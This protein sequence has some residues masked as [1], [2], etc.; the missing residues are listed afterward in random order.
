MSE[1]SLSQSA[2]YSARPTLRFSGQEDARASQLVTAM[3]MDEDEGGMSRLELRLSNWASDTAGGAALAFPAGSKLALGAGIE[4]YVGD[5]AEPREIF[6]GRIS[7]IEADFRTGMPPEISVLAEDALQAARMARR[8]KV[9]PK[10]SP[11]EVVEA[12]ARGLGLKPV[13]AGLAAPLST[14][15]Q[16]DESDLAFLRRLLARFDADLQIVGDE[17]HVSPRADVA[18]GTLELQL[19]GQLGRARVIADLA[20]Q[21]TEVSVRGWNAAQGAAV[22]GKATAGTHLGPG[23]GHDGKAVLAATFGARAERLS[24]VSVASDDEARAVAQAAFDRRARR[25]VRVDATTEGNARLRVGTQVRLAGLDSRFDNTY[26][27]VRAA[28]L[29]DTRQGYRTEFGAECAW[30]GG[31]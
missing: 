2:I 5:E 7:A 10:Q 14:S 12:V 22:E 23:S 20:D 9:Y 1:A 16:L 24:H 28:H 4:V 19:Y 26:Y 25:F 17:L 13:V 30:L 6:R 3:R 31:A 18:R 15:A 21:V 8:S 27:V 11:K 29:Y